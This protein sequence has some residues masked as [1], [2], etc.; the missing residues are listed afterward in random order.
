VCYNRPL[1]DHIA[2]IAPPGEVATYHQLADRLSRALGQ[3][4]DFSQPGVF[5]R[6]EAFMDGYAPSAADRFDEIIIDE[7]QDFRAG[8]ADNLLRFLRPDGAPGGWKTPAEPVRPPR[9][10]CPAG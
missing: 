3:V 9:A 1:A 4:P 6:L 5:D 8:W 7:G 2:L 10:A